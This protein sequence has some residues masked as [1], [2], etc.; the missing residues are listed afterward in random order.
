[1]KLNLEGLHE[2]YR[3]ATR[4]PKQLILENVGEPKETCARMA[5]HRTSISDLQPAVQ[6]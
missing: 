2:K 1:M 4:E 5:D 3:V 6:N